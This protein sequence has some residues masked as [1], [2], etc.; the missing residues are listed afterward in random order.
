[1]LHP[2]ADKNS[3]F[4]LSPPSL[5][6]YLNRG[7]YRMGASIFTTNFLYFGGRP[8][9]AVW[10]RQD[11]R[12]FAFSRSQRKLMRRNAKLFDLN[13]A[14]RTIDRERNE[15]YYRYAADFDGRLSPTINDNLEDYE[16]STTPFNTWETTIRDKVS[17]QLVG[18]SYYDLGED[19]V[20][21]ILGVYDPNLKSFSLG[22]YTML[23]E[24]EYCLNNGIR[25]YYPGYV[26]PGYGRFDY[27]LRSGDS[28]YFDLH[29]QDWLPYD[30]A[31]IAAN[32]PVEIQERK[33]REL[34][35]LLL[36]AER[37]EQ[38]LLIYPFFEAGLYGL[39]EE[40]CLPYPFFYAVGREENDLVVVVVFDPRDREYLLLRCEHERDNPQLTLSQPPAGAVRDRTFPDMLHCQTVLFRTQ[41]PTLMA[42]ACLHLRGAGTQN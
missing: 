26:V 29:A 17:G 2:Y 16:T 20:A 10:I 9:S 24:I 18:L 30:A 34:L 4:V 12:E 1:M 36:P 39:Q 42:K 5:D 32:G 35:G 40:H 8:Y 13:W 11:L 38:R 27:K 25:Y 21:S 14:P 22:Y 23:L 3:P 15:L 33:L 41:S 31:E 19:A 6:W 7:W 28:E 37:V